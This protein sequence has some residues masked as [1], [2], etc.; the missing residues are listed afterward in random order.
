[1][2]HTSL[3][4]VNHCLSFAVSRTGALLLP[5]WTVITTT[6]THTHAAS[7]SGRWRVAKNTTMRNMT[8]TSTYSLCMGMRRPV[9]QLP[10]AAALPQQQIFQREKGAS[11]APEQRRWLQESQAPAWLL[12][13][14]QPADAHTHT[15][16]A[17]VS[18]PNCH[19]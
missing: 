14:A 8:P 19:S 3:P 12:A 11:H 9:L 18:M 1:M 15:Y 6:T 13:P 16:V 5:C 4:D 17:K 10:N 7:K 2:L